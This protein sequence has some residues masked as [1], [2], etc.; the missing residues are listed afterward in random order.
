M[1]WWIDASQQR[2][3]RSLPSGGH[4][5]IDQEAGLTRLGLLLERPPATFLPMPDHLIITVLGIGPPVLHGQRIE[6]G[7]ELLP[8]QPV[9]GSVQVE[10]G[11]FPRH[12]SPY[13]P[14]YV[15]E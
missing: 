3:P 7:E 5:G 10:I 12:Y 9:D 2:P 11:V 6:V 4:D 1:L 13:F 15:S 14:A 8:G